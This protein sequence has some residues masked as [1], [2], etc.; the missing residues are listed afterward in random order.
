M[1]FEENLQIKNISNPKSLLLNQPGDKENSYIQFKNWSSINKLEFTNDNQPFVLYF[2]NYNYDKIFV[3]DDLIDDIGIAIY[4]VN[5][6]QST[7]NKERIEPITLNFEGNNISFKSKLSSDFDFKAHKSEISFANTPN[8]LSNLTMFT[9]EEQKSYELPKTYL[10]GYGEIDVDIISKN[11][12]LTV[13]IV[14]EV[15]ELKAANRS[16]LPSLKRFIS[17]NL[18]AIVITFLSGV[19]AAIFSLL[20]EKLASNKE[21]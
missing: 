13:D 9:I 8:E 12:S 2:Y 10:Q 15:S 3:K 17:E 6:F 18:S 21:K 19:I 20:T 16:L 7:L 11:N 14:G 4:P 1:K 5:N